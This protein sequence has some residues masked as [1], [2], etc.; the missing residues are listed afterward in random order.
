M[1]SFEK[2]TEN[3]DAQRLREILHPEQ[4]VLRRLGVGIQGHVNQALLETPPLTILQLLRALEIAE[5]G[6]DGSGPA[7]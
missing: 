1:P 6:Q 5:R 2:P 3:E 4:D 7:H